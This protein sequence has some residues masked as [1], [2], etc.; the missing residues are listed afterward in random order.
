VGN[1]PW[2]RM[3][4]RLPHGWRDA[5]LQL[6]L[7][8]L[9][10][11]LY[12][13]VRGLVAGQ[14]TSALAH[15]NSIYALEKATG[16]DIEHWAQSL[17]LGSGVLETLSNWTYLNVQFTVNA[18]FLAWV[19]SYRNDAFKLVRNTFFVAMGMALI[20]HLVY[21]VAPPRL[22]PGF[23]DTVHDIAHINQDS[24]A[25]GVMV[26]PYAAVPSMHM[27]FALI[28]GVT[29]MML[30]RGRTL[31]LVWLA[32][33]TIVF[34]AILV[35]ANHFVF[36]AAAGAVTALVATVAARRLPARARR[37][38]AAPATAR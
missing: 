19:Y 28:I 14:A 18:L 26:N 6:S 4:Y 10:D 9:A 31:R 13:G 27:C 7:W 11:L 1:I 34:A 29:G 36:D 12:E 21:P 17:V 2:N 22:L 3:R 23:T 35:T 25:I 8:G 32:Y 5:V 24:G 16:T 30:A 37:T 33:P 20:V 15:A 38:V